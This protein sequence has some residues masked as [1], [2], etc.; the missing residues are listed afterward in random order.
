[1]ARYFDYPT[2]DNKKSGGTNTNKGT[3]TSKYVQN[4]GPY[5]SYKPSYVAPT[6]TGT[7]SGVPWSNVGNYGSGRGT[8]SY[9]N[10]GDVG[11][12][13]GGSSGKPVGD[14]I[15]GSFVNNLKDLQLPTPQDQNDDDDKGGTPSYGGSSG[16]DYS[17]W[18][19]MLMGLADSQYNA[20]AK[21]YKEQYERANKQANLSA[22]L[23]L[24][25][26]EGMGNKVGNLISPRGNV[27]A[28][29][30][31]A[32]RDNR[33]KYDENLANANTQRLG[34]MQNLAQM[35]PQMDTNNIQNIMAMVKKRY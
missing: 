12:G 6:A 23:S 7:Y 2:D 9:T 32:L 24:K 1:M 16:F 3:N 18:F 34:W 25:K 14:G 20:L 26:L 22:K 5:G 31:V 19:E 27:Y 11:G 10:Y 15:I 21:A 8:M 28:N 33:S 29:R 35:L 13:N 17:P 4:Y 30:D